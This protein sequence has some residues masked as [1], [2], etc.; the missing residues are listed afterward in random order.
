[1]EGFEVV[2][3]EQAIQ[4][5]LHMATGSG[6]SVIRQA[7]FLTETDIDLQRHFVSPGLLMVGIR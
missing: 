7:Q 4:L 6:A 2:L 3:W 5:K 1:M